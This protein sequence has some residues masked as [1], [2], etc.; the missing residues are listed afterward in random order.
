[1][2]D[3]RKELTLEPAQT[4]MIGDTMSTDILGGLELGYSTVLVLTGGTKKSELSNFAFQPNFVVDSVADL[5][6]DWF[7]KRLGL[8]PAFADAS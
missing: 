1:M 4:F 3:A 8:E 6:N 5:N 2:R 7:E